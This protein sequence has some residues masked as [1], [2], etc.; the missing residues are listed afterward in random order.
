MICMKIDTPILEKTSLSRNISHWNHISLF[1]RNKLFCYATVDLDGF[2]VSLLKWSSTG[3]TSPHISNSWWVRHENCLPSMR[4][5]RQ[6]STT[7]KSS[8]RHSSSSMNLPVDNWYRF[9][10]S[11]MISL[12][13][14]P[15][16]T[17]AWS[18]YSDNS[19]LQTFAT[20][21]WYKKQTRESAFLRHWGEVNTNGN[22]PN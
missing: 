14:G 18:S 22:E 2:V 9:P 3:L 10:S 1:S 6:D 20:T 17:T 15:K 11:G 19:W 5:L 7:W 21:H 12:T 13:I 16:T 8:L 4:R